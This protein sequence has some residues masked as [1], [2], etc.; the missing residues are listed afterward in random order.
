MLHT[1]PCEGVPYRKGRV[2]RHA[3][4]M[5]AP[6]SKLITHPSAAEVC[7]HPSAH[8]LHYAPWPRSQTVAHHV[9]G[10]AV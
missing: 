10:I 5:Q 4:E 9:G 2:T 7:K 6:V 8:N 1:L 3:L